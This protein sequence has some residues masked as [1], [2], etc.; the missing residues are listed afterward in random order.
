[1]SKNLADM[2]GCSL[3]LAG[4]HGETFLLVGWWDRYRGS[5]MTSRDLKSQARLRQLKD[6]G[7]HAGDHPHAPATQLM[8][9]SQATIKAVAAARGVCV[10]ARRTDFDSIWQRAEPSVLGAVEVTDECSEGDLDAA[11]N[12]RLDLLG[13]AAGGQK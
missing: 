8:G 13:E 3:G 1:M 6:V 7:G 5:L 10:A 2:D 12:M 4:D 11:K 9:V